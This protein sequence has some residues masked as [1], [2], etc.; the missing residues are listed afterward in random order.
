MVNNGM[1]NA[2]YYK[3]GRNSE[4]EPDG[5]LEFLF[6]LDKIHCN[7]SNQI[8]GSHLFAVYISFKKVNLNNI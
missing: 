1:I 4:F 5:D 2:A 7:I 3:L 6:L 8:S